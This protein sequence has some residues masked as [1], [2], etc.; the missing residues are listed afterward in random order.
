MGKTG[1]GKSELINAIAGSEIA[2]TGG[3]RPMRHMG[4]WHEIGSLR[5]Y[6]NQGIEISK[7]LKLILEKYNDSNA[8]ILGPSNANPEKIKD[9]YLMQ[10]II[11]CATMVEAKK[12]RNLSQ[13]YIDFI[14][15]NKLIKILFDIE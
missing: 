13:K 11:K 3:F 8:I 12:Y 1:V 7:N 5:I 6:D 14:D 9:I 10:I 4:T 15:K 2:E